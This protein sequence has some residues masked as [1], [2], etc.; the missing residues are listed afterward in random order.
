MAM[1]VYRKVPTTKKNDQNTK[2]PQVLIRSHHPSSVGAST[3]EY[4]CLT[5]EMMDLKKQTRTYFPLNP[6]WLIG[7]LIFMVYYNPYITG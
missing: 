1:L 3:S 7:I 6:G 4:E 2:L 5:P